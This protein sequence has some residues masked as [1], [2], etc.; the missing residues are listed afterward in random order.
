[1][2][3][4]RVG[5]L[6]VAT[7]GALAGAALAWRLGPGADPFRL[8]ARI[9][10][11]RHVLDLSDR[12]A[13]AVVAAQAPGDPVREDRLRPGGGFEAPR[14]AIVTPPP[15]AVSWRVRVPPG[16]RLEFDAA[17][18][19]TRRGREG[20]DVRFA[21]E[22]DGRVVWERTLNPAVHRRHRRWIAGD[23]DLGVAE[24]REVALTLRTSVEGRGTPVGPAGWSHL[25]IVR[26]ET[27]AR[28]TASPAA[29]S[30][31][32]LLVDT[33]R[34]D[35]VGAYGASPSPTPTLDRVAARGRVF[36]NAVSQAPWTLPAVT[37]F[38]TG[39]PPRTHGVV[40]GAAAPDGGG[41]PSSLPHAVPTI[42]ELAAA[43]GVTTVGVSTN[44]LVSRDTNLARG[45]ETFV[46]YGWDGERGDWAGADRVNETFRRW[47]APN[48]GRRFFGWLHYMEPHDPYTPP[49]ALRPPVPAGVRPAL[50][51]GR[52]HRVAVA[53]NGRTAPPLPAV[54]VAY[55][56]ALYDAEVTAWD[57]ALAD[58][59]ATL[60]AAG[61]ADS[62]V[63]VV[64]ADHG[65]AFQEHGLLKHRVHLYDEMLRIPF[66]LAGPG[67][68]PGREPT[69]VQGIDVFPT[70]AA[71]LGVAVPDDRP[72]ENVLAHPTPRIAVSET[73][74]GI[75]AS[76]GRAPLLA[77]RTDAWKLIHAPRVGETR[78]FDLR[79]DPG[80]QRDV[81]GTSP[82]RA[83]LLA[84][85]E[86]WRTATPAPAAPPAAAPGLH[87]KL[88]ALGYVD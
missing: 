17:V 47:L 81:A 78:L 79:T 44:P 88:R 14:P 8:P 3:R 87:E 82:E 39:L 35:R 84:A 68:A 57:A 20:A 6:V 34:A 55:L 75:T 48:R 7:G 22:V 60:D 31:L 80:E 69:Q 9:T 51:R 37:T 2:T 24:E 21:V 4:R 86:A 29:P 56:R 1:M 62:T 61:V 26:R 10:V 23:V 33:L 19:R 15:A 41:D 18:A 72:G 59:L 46:E 38:L 43:A 85:L 67:I 71:L 70:L 36:A 74:S 83:A 16:A 52:V 5:A 40:G 54:E 12:L 49:A 45:F 50:A 32:V 58:V 25:R 63:L 64:L 27:R 76:G 66:V 73:R 53:V 11:E 30:V 28:Q 13:A 42:A 65:E 77:A